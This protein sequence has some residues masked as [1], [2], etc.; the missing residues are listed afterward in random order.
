MACTLFYVPHQ[1]A[2]WDA[3]SILLRRSSDTDA[4]VRTIFNEPHYFGKFKEVYIL[5]AALIDGSTVHCATHTRETTLFEKKVSF[6]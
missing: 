6:A 5:A 1:N 3:C 4:R 2:Y